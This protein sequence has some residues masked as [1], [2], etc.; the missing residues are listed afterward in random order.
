VVLHY[1]RDREKREVDFLTLRERKPE[2]LI[3]AKWADDSLSASLAYY[4]EKIR[5][6]EAIQLVRKTPR[7]L[8]F[9]RCKILPAAAWLSELEG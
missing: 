1:L 8:Q 6:L 2:Y 3:E 4:A 7:K 5:P 9:G